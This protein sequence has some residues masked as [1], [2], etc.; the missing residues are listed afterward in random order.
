MPQELLDEAYRT[1]Y[2]ELTLED[3]RGLVDA[4]RNIEHLGRLKS[5]LLKIQ[6]QREFKAVSGEAG[7]VIRENATK[8]IEQNLEQKGIKDA[9][10]SNGREVFA[11]HRKFASLIRQMDGFKDGG[12]L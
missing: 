11:W 6:D 9:V 10:A 5:K 2:K 4:V 3:F 8:D 7:D 1:S 12:F